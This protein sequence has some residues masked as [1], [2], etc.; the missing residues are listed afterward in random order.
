L[1][2]K[3]IFPVLHIEKNAAVVIAVAYTCQKER[4]L[5]DCH[6]ARI[7]G[8]SNPY[9]LNPKSKTFSSFPPDSVSRH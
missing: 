7:A 5:T 4:F 9:S 8:G 6:A 2:E 1:A 3:N